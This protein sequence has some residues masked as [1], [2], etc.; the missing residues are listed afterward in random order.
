MTLAVPLLRD[1]VPP[2]PALRAAHRGARLVGVIG[3]LL[4]AAGAQKDADSVVYAGRA[5]RTART[6]LGVHGVDVRVSA[7]PTGGPFLVVANH[8]SY[9]D[10]LVVSS[11]VPCIS[12]AKGETAGWPLVGPGLRALGVVFV[13]RGDG[14]SGA[15]ALRQAWRAL[16]AGVSVLN[17]PEGTTS[18]GRQVGPF[19]RGVF[20]LAM[21][22]GAPILP[23]RLAFDDARAPWFGGATF[24][25]HY[26]KLAG[27]E[28]VTVHVR[29]GDP[30]DPRPHDDA[31]S[32]A[33]RV[34][35]I[36]ATL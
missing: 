27:V 19:R 11:V 25:P 4:A 36:V 17:F 3:R 7:A 1:R 14:Y 24:A 6:I 22:S 34:Q 33:S 2:W 9:L 12:I 20:G 8:V 23:V 15:T 10:P 21:L 28:R 16:R 26:W 30:I 32:L 5:A 29:I 18:D 35:A 31:Q 13:R